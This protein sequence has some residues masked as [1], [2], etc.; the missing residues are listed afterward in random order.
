MTNS[1]NHPVEELRLQEVLP[2]PLPPRM[3]KSLVTL[4]Q[5]SY[6]SIEGE[7]AI[8]LKDRMVPIKVKDI[9][10][11]LIEEVKKN[12]SLAAIILD[13]LQEEMKLRPEAEKQEYLEMIEILKA[14]IEYAYE[15]IGEIDDLEKEWL[16][17]CVFVNTPQIID[18]QPYSWGELALSS[19]AMAWR[20]VKGGG[21]VIYFV[22]DR[23]LLN[24]KLLSVA[25][26]VGG[27]ASIMNL[28]GNSFVVVKLIGF[29]L[30]RLSR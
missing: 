20:V 5:S 13:Q 2:P 27:A 18:H 23:V 3:R 25:A 29:I 11:L 9:L 21:S 16:E 19:G 17:E 8:D 1:T 4:Q 26:A 6:R 28:A 14:N 24:D 30:Q 15:R 22:C 12:D 10:L 7:L